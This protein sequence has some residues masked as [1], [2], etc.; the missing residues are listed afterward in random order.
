PSAGLAIRAVDGSG[1]RLNALSAAL[2]ALPVPVV[3]RIEDNALVLDFR[4]LEDEAGFIDNLGNI[5]VPS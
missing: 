3:G 2:R 4:C 5:R 1:S